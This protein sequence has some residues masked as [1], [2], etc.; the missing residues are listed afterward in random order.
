MASMK[1]NYTRETSNHFS[2]LK[3]NDWEEIQYRPIKYG[4]YEG[5]EYRAIIH[6]VS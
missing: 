1:K 4:Y 2:A 5:G 6:W 3:T